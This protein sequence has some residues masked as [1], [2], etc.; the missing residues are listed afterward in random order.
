[1]ADKLA[2]NIQHFKD[3]NITFEPSQISTL[4]EFL[5]TKVDPKDLGEDMFR[6]LNSVLLCNRAEGVIRSLNSARQK[7][8]K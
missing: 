2:L 8:V 1:M 3:R 6:K 4:M 7:L 5:H